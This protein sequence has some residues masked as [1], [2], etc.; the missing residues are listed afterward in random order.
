MEQAGRFNIVKLVIYQLMFFNPNS[1][2]ERLIVPTIFSKGY[3]SIEVWHLEVSNFLTFPN[4]L[5]SLG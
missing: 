3:F 2:G 1:W 4:S 5:W